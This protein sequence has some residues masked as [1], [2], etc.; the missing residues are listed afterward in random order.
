M[1]VKFLAKAFFILALALSTNGM[2]ED[3]CAPPDYLE[4]TCNLDCPQ[5]KCHDV[6]FNQDGTLFQCC[7]PV[8][9]PE[10]PEWVNPLYLALF[11]S[12]GF[13]AWNSRKEKLGL[14]RAKR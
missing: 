1:I 11:L 7:P 3:G 5:E 12:I 10:L 4:P 14:A 13:L 6:S 9:I 2:A 8:S